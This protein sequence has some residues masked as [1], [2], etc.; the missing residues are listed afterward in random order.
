MKK[1]VAIL[2]LTFTLQSCE[3]KNNLENSIWKSCGDD[4]TVTD[5]MVFSEEHL[6]VKNDSIYSHH[7][8]SLIGVIDTIELYYGERRLYVKNLTKGCV[9]RYCE[10]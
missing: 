4:C 8:N 1:V 5:V 9:A 10:Q 3:D 2:I 7:N 6:Y